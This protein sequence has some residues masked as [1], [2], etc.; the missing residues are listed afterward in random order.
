MSEPVKEEEEVA[1]TE[2][3]DNAE[4]AEAEVCIIR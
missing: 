1:D 2:N 4:N 3:A